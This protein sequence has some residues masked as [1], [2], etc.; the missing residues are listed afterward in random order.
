MCTKKGRG[1]MKVIGGML[2]MKRIGLYI[3]KRDGLKRGRE[4]IRSECT[5]DF[6]YKV[7]LNSQSKP[8]KWQKKI[9][10][11]GWGGTNATLNVYLSKCHNITLVFAHAYV[12][13]YTNKY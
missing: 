9:K 11:W 2:L 10:N 7:K 4:S 1:R 12:S 3:K 8:L 5:F 13:R 6:E